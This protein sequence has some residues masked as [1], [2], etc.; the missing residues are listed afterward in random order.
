MATICNLCTR[1]MC[2]QADSTKHLAPGVDLHPDDEASPTCLD[3]LWCLH[4]NQLPATIFHQLFALHEGLGFHRWPWLKP[5][6]PC[7][8]ISLDAEYVLKAAREQLWLGGVTQDKPTLPTSSE[9]LSQMKHR[10]VFSGWTLPIWQC[11]SMFMEL[12]CMGLARF[13]SR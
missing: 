2:S 11:Q 5:S 7:S 12:L 4:E 1:G 6:R 13:M 8:C 3:P 9:W 10:R